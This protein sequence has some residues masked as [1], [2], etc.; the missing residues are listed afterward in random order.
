MAHKLTLIFATLAVLAAAALAAKPHSAFDQCF[1]IA[2]KERKAN[3]RFS[4]GCWRCQLVGVHC[5][6]KCKRKCWKIP[7][8]ILC[9]VGLLPGQ[10]VRVR[11]PKNL[12]PGGRYFYC[13]AAAIVEGIC[14]CKPGTFCKEQCM[15]C[16]V[17]GYACPSRCSS[18]PLWWKPFCTP[19]NCPFHITF[20]HGGWR[21]KSGRKK[22]TGKN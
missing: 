14:K 6:D 8:R 7:F 19:L 16:G 22:A 3:Y 15:L 20:N 2:A 4:D 9:Q 1:D 17:R 10:D 21:R 11:F 13:L 12:R 5:P 18:Q